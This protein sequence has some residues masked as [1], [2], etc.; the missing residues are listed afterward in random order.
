M[1][2]AR[3]KVGPPANAAVPCRRAISPPKRRCQRTISSH[4]LLSQCHRAPCHRPIPRQARRCH[5]RRLRK[6]NMHPSN[7]IAILAF[8]RR[9]EKVLVM[10]LA[11]VAPSVVQNEMLGTRENHEAIRWAEESP[12]SEYGRARQLLFIYWVAYKDPDV[13]GT[14]QVP[15]QRE[16]VESHGLVPRYSRSILC[17]K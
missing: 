17:R 4:P 14:R 10:T 7:C 12:L 16:R 5:P 1:R 15:K 2:A 13:L 6:N 3:P 11:A 8:F 9:T